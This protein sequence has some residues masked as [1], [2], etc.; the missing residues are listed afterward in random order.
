MCCKLP[1]NCT[2]EKI[3][4]FYDLNLNLSSF[5]NSEAKKLHNKKMSSNLL[6]IVLLTTSTGTVR[7]KLSNKAANMFFMNPAPT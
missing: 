3:D 6:S 5:F 2:N 1:V 4:I 7:F